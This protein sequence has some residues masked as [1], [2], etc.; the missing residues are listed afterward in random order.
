[1]NQGPVPS[2]VSVS[3][4]EDVPA[5]ISVIASDFDTDSLVMVVEKLPSNGTL[6]KN[7]LL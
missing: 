2:V 4:Q 1:M 7:I 5:S 6:Y 3:T